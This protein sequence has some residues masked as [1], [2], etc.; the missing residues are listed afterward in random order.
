MSVTPPAANGM[1][2]FTGL[3]GYCC[4]AAGHANINA[5]GTI[6]LRMMALMASS[7]ASW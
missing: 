3:L 1:M 2:I 5:N 6:K 4:A 7:L